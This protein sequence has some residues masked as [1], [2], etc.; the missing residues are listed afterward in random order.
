M[1]KAKA[2]AFTIILVMMAVNFITPRP[3]VPTLPHKSWQWL[4]PWPT[5]IVQATVAPAMT[6]EDLQRIIVGTIVGF[7]VRDFAVRLERLVNAVERATRG[8]ESRGRDR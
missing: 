6:Y 4:T 7:L 3:W 2:F 1:Q 5:Q 8:R